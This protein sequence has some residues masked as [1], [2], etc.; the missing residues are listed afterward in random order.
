MTL[1][2][3]NLFES[4]LELSDLGT[5]IDSQGFLEGKNESDFIDL[6]S[7]IFYLLTEG[8]ILNS[9]NQGIGKSLL[10][11]NAWVGSIN[12]AIACHQ[13]WAKILKPTRHP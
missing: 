12:R 3:P 13:W 2:K 9:R 5:C 11:A 4:M 1:L 10:L 7:K 6:L 8:K